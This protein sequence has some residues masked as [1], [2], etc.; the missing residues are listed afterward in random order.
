MSLPVTPALRAELCPAGRVR[1]GINHSNFLLVK[2][3]SPHGAPQ[4]I[5]PDLALELAGRLG[6][7]IEYVSFD[8]AGKLADAV[9]SAA[10]DVGF[11]AREAERANVIAFSSAY[12][13]LP[14]TYLVPAG[15]PIRTIAEVDRDGVRVAVSARSA[16]DLYLTRTLQHAKLVRAE[17][18]PASYALFA[19]EKLDA[20]AGLKP[21]LLTHAR[22]LPGARV[23]D[24]QFTAVQQSIGVPKGRAAAAAYLREFVE[25]VKRSGLVARLV[26]RHGVSGVNVAPPE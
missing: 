6:V 3:G 12:L 24:G 11:L 15:S 14:V 21:G 25:D 1:A 10:V 16:Y 13:E 8:G 26:E 23:L 2:P 5:A 7:P 22:K 17:G 19:E 9:G 4:G 18:I 20:V